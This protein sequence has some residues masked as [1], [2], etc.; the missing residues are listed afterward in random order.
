MKVFKRITAIVLV[1]LFAFSPLADCALTLRGFAEDAVVESPILPIIPSRP[2]T[3]LGLVYVL[4]DTALTAKVADFTDPQATFA[5]IPREVLDGEKTYTVN[6]IASAAF[7]ASST[8]ESV[9]IPETVKNIE[10]Y[11]FDACA[12][13][14]TV[15]FEGDKAAFSQISIA[16][17]NDDLLNAELHCGACMD[18]VGPEFTHVYDSFSD[19][20]CNACGKERAI[21][22][23]FV[24]GDLD[25]KE[26][27]DLDDVIYLLYHVNFSE[28]YPIT[29]NVDFDASGT[30]DLDD[31]FYLLYHVNFPDR[32]P[33]N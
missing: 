24:A 11:A 26:G 28:K 14:K 15:W 1:A 13:L 32:Y 33:L 19:P 31:V 23:D 17:G 25:D 20:D 7:S 21:S 16:A 4:D 3:D 30:V 18:R 9:V 29:Q 27:V 12:K 22:E 2:D 10:A 6:A 5:V 8:L